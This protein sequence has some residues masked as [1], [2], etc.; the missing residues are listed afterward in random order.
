[1]LFRGEMS[2]RICRARAVTEDN[3]NR[4]LSEKVY[5]PTVGFVN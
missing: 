1:M 4:T 3:A 5:G 2:E